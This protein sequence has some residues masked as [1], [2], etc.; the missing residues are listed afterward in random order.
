MSKL[1]LRHAGAF[2]AIARFEDIHLVNFRAR[3]DA[4][5]VDLAVRDFEAL[6]ADHNDRRLGTILVVEANIPL[7]EPDIRLVTAGQLSRVQR[8]SPYRAAVILGEGRQVLAKLKPLYEGGVQTGGNSSAL[9]DAAAAAVVAS[10]GSTNAGVID[11]LAGC[12][13]AAHAAE[14]LGSVASAG[15]TS[16]SW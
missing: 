4:G 11:D 13:D 14:V 15:C 1:E 7:P 5:V 16:A 9:V 12:A 6:A 8:H 2:G 10:A 3:I